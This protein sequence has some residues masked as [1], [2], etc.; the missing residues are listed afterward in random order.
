MSTSLSEE[1]RSIA[2]GEI[3]N[4]EWNRK[5]Y[6]VDASHY[7]LVPLAVAYP[8]DELDLQQICQYCFDRN[9]PSAARGAGTG[10]LGQSLANGLVLDFTKHMNRIIEVEEDYVLVEPGIVKGVLDRE[11]KRRGK[12]L[13]PDP[14][15]SNYC[16][17]GGM[18]ANNS[19]GPH[20]LL[21]GST[22]DF[23]EG[24]GVVYANGSYH[25]ISDKYSDEDK[26]IKLLK[27]LSQHEKV[28]RVGFPQVRKN[29]CGYR[30]D[31]VISDEGFCPH[32]LFAGSEGTLGYVTSAKLKILDL[33]TYR[34][35]QVLAFEDLLSAI[36][37]L[38]DILSFSPSAVEMLDHSALVTETNCADS[39]KG[40]L[41]FV[42]FASNSLTDLERRSNNCQ[43]RMTRSCTIIETASDEQSMDRIWAAR[44]GAL[45]NVMK[46]TVG[47][48]RP[49]GL[50]E[51]TVVKIN[52]LYDYVIY[53]QKM[54]Y[55]NKLD[56]VM[57]GHLGDG[58]I[59]TR[60]IVDMDRPED[61]R[62]IQYL[63]DAVFSQVI[64]NKGTIT[65]EHGDGLA[66]VDYIPKLYGEF[67]FNLFRE[68][69][70]L[71]DPGFLLNPGKKFSRVNIH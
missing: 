24:L 17:I 68:V 8:T 32:K 71:F 49:I 7:S 9:I 6:S 12:F 23:I 41:L 43:Y 2:K 60:P 69:K 20:G 47:S 61:I 48:R 56:F 53:L 70:Q 38:P 35:L 26:T 62:L 52:F 31:A 40:C 25:Y 34:H 44:R 37:I 19:G 11:L 50:I 5:I 39:S 13:P 14:A 57:Y 16:T 22:I 36:T 45:N 65:G 3:F 4:D 18:I 55:E 51:D 42:E 67:I 28:I 29:S 46:I 58:N 30:L 64:K 66:R 54:Y 21:Y 27:Q 63:A 1:L 33:P 15:S 10:L 59:H